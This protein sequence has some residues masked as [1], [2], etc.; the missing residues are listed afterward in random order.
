MV[1]AKKLAILIISSTS[2]QTK[3]SLEEKHEAEI[4]PLN[5]AEREIEAL[6]ADV[7]I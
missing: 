6:E 2:S 3:S 5:K 4:K 7:H 1:E